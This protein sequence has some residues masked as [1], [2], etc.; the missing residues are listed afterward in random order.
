MT[1]GWGSGDVVGT[2]PEF[3]QQYGLGRLAFREAIAILEMRGW[4]HS[5]RG[6]GGGLVL[7]L[8]SVQDISTLTMVYLCLKGACTDQLIEAH[9]S[10]HQAVVRKLVMCGGRTSL[11][12]RVSQREHG[13]AKGFPYIFAEHRFFTLACRSNRQSLLRFHH[14]LCP[15]TL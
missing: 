8:P 15:R 5:R 2:L 12:L 13:C 14:G 1:N 7:T 4:V 11:T 9:R 6:G 10:V 3:C